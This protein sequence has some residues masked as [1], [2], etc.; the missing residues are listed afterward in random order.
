MANLIL[1]T[2]CQRKCSY[3]FAQKDR[4]RNVSFTW[5]NF[6]TASNFI[7]TTEPKLINLLGGE[8]T[9]HKDFPKILEY[10]ILN[11]FT[12]Q[13]F[14]NGMVTEK[15]MDEISKVLKRVTLREGQLRFGVNV[16]KKEDRITNETEMQRAFFKRFYKI[17]YPAFTI[18]EKEVDLTF[19]VNLIQEYLLEPGIRLGIAMPVIGGNNKYLSLDYY[20][21]AAKNIIELSKKSPNITITL[22]CGFPLCMF[23]MSEIREL[24][25]NENN[26]FSFVCG[27][28]LDIY[29]DLTIT[30][31]YPLSSLCKVNMKDF[32]NIVEVYKFF[33]EGFMTPTGIYG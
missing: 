20:K 27:Q 32:T 26:D 30:N 31:C 33:R 14:T 1:T 21:D 9:L 12:I 16:N 22:D 13:V 17:T 4:D 15:R 3:C 29:P 11:D 7:A 18:Y 6:I 25:Q 5:D 28:P 19:L 23:S 8:P 10:L 2:D 24:S